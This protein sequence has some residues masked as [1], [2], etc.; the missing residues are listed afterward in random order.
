MLTAYYDDSGSYGDTKALVVCGFVSSI[1]QCLL[2]EQDWNAVLEMPRFDLKHLHMKELRSGKGRFAKFKDNLPLQ[3]DLFERL[4]DT[5]RTRTLRTF[6]G[7]ISL[8][9]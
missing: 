9:D 2:F 6:A 4:H 3:R 1:D 7:A 8:I 5:V